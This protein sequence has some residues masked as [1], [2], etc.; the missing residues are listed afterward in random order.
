MK[1]Y[2]LKPPAV[3]WGMVF[4]VTWTLAF[5]LRNPIDFKGLIPGL[6]AMTP[7]TDQYDCNLVRENLGRSYLWFH[8]EH[9]S[10]RNVRFIS[11]FSRKLAVVLSDSLA[12]FTCLFDHGFAALFARKRGL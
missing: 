8:H 2:Y 12:L 3:S 11:K 9:Y 7:R 10:Y 4:P 1:T 6:I 5:Y